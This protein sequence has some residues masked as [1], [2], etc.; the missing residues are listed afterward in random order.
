M[1]FTLL[2]LHQCHQHPCRT[3]PQVRWSS[4]AVPVS[5][6]NFK[7]LWFAVP[8]SPCFLLPLSCMAWLYSP[9]FGQK[10]GT[11]HGRNGSSHSIYGL[12]PYPS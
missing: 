4:S 12:L 7:E 6:E 10:L 2:T 11:S 5:S 9:K 8:S 1:L 3:S